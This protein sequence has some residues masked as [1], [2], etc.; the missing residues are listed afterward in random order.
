M[1]G[2]MGEEDIGVGTI[3]II[4]NYCFFFLISVKET[5]ITHITYKID[6]IIDVDTTQNTPGKTTLNIPLQCSHTLDIISSL[7]TVPNPIIRTITYKFFGKLTFN[8]HMALYNGNYTTPYTGWE[9]VLSTEEVLYVG[10]FFL[11]GTSNY[12]LLMQ[13]CYATP[14]NDMNDPQKYQFFQS[15]CS[16]LEYSILSIDE[17]SSSN[18]GRFSVS[19]FKY[20]GN[21]NSAYV[22]CAMRVCDRST[23]PVSQCACNEPGIPY[24]FNVALTIGP[25]RRSDPIPTT[26][27]SGSSTITGAH[28]FW[29]LLIPALI[30]LIQSL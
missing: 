14:T 11:G 10:V 25:I 29:N 1:V 28:I 5:N 8:V 18:K 21:N 15:S 7:N 26:P 12:V 13:N 9:A 3:I 24:S 4:F 27:E 16:K 19:L 2:V 23:V 20:V 17:G 22:H 6:I 30:I